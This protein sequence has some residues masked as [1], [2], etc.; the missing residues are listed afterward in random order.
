MPH[1][2][3]S[4]IEFHVSAFVLGWLFP[5]LGHIALGQKRRG[6]LV[7]FGI[8]FLVFFGVLVGGIDAVDHKHDGLWF[9]A[10]VWCGPVVIAIDLLNQKL[11]VPLPVSQRATL[12]GLSHANEIGTLFI[13]MAG[14][15]NFVV[16]LDAL[17]AKQ[18]HDLERRC[19]DNTGADS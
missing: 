5:G 15:M 19:A 6:F 12:V 7:M 4:H 9:I 16:L 14:L 2:N 11:I 1:T 13:A 8:L 17:Q 3:K 10:Q 18:N